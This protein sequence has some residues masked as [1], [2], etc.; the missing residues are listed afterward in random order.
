MA[1]AQ[2]AISLDSFPADANGTALARGQLIAA[3]NEGRRWVN[4]FGHASPYRWSGGG[5]LTAAQVSAGVF[6]N[7]QSPFLAVQWGCWGAYYVLPEYDSMAHGLLLNEGG[8]VALIGASALTET[9]PSTALASR[10][11][12]KLDQA[13][14]LGDAWREGLIEQILSNPDSADVNVGTVLLGDPSLPLR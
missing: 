6:D 9:G 13:D 12:P 5:L 10:L 14:R 11:L 2:A 3:A 7:A 1:G 8:A 4:Y